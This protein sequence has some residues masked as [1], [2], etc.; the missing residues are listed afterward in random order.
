MTITSFLSVS[1]FIFSKNSPSG[2]WGLSRNERWKTH[3]VCKD[4]IEKMPHHF[5]PRGMLSSFPITLL[6]WRRI[7][8]REQY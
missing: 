4:D 8:D 6:S 1:P 7:D 3:P 2:L 5:D